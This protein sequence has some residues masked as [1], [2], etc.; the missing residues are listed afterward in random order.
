MN[1]ACNYRTIKYESFSAL[2]L[3][4]PNSQ[5]GTPTNIEHILRRYF[6]SEV[7]RDA[8]CDQ[9]KENS[10]KQKGFL[11]KHGIVKMPQTLLIRLERVGMLPSGHLKLN[12]HVSFSEHL[13]VQEVC[14]RRDFRLRKEAYEES[15]RKWE[16]ADGSARVFGGAEI[17]DGLRGKVTSSLLESSDPR[18]P[19]ISHA[20]LT[21]GHAEAERHTYQLRAV[22]EHRGGPFSG[23]F[24]T[25]RRGPAPNS[26]NWFLTNDSQV[27]QVAYKQ[28][29][30]CQAYMLF[31]ERLKPNRWM[32]EPLPSKVDVIVLGTGLP[33][34]I[35]AA[36][37]A[38]SGL[39]VVHLDR[40]PFY[41]ADWTSLNLDCVHEWVNTQAP[42][43]ENADV[44]T[45]EKFLEEGEELVLL[46]DNK[47]VEDVEHG[48]LP[49][50]ST[51]IRKEEE[52]VEG[53]EKEEKEE[54]T[55]EEILKKSARRFSIDVLPKVLLA[56]G[57]MVQVLCDSQVSKY[58]EF[59]L[60]DRQLCPLAEAD[61][62]ISFHRVPC[63]KGEIFTSQVLSTMDKRFLM[64]FITF[65]TQWRAS[66]PED[67]RNAI[68]DF[69]DKPF[70]EFLRSQKLPENLRSYI[71]STIGILE[72]QPTTAKGLEAVC[73][74]M[75]SVGHFGPSPFLFPLYGNG[76]MAQYY[77]RLSAVFGSLYCLG[78]PIDFVV[79]K[80][81][82]I[83][84]VITN[85]Q[86]VNCD[87]VIMSQ[88]YLPKSVPLNLTNFQIQRRIFITNRS[89]LQEDKEFITLIN[90][91][92]LRN[93]TTTRIIEAGFE[94]CLAP[95][96]YLLVHVTGKEDEKQDL[97]GFI[98]RLFKQKDISPLWQM[99]FKMRNSVTEG[100]DLPENVITT[101]SV[102]IDL[103]FSSLIEECRKLFCATWPDRDF[104]PRMIE[105][106][107]E[108]EEEREVEKEEDEAIES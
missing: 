53:E 58:A 11:K 1:S 91:S 5:M 32:D 99:R 94:A 92:S 60:V 72:D 8:T 12:E 40:N 52:A 85:G 86:R 9:C 39:S 66:S 37:C 56:K 97:D 45:F 95:K 18:F 51:S 89:I 108:E 30:L 104:L 22:C 47:L 74:F 93:G 33:E 14:F 48:W 62:N 64:K 78:K 87:H 16:L 27:N 90:A 46:G 82:R 96:G 24:V 20:K 70:D 4:I 34:A 59:K 106:N 63:S 84:G 7:I 19:S 3:T 35:L 77:C 10:R 25:Y 38:R 54:K 44:S 103:E 13:S 68:K 50:C 42:I 105:T 29:G 75:D 36:A 43:Q 88:T 49:A 57:D 67:A 101:P 73:R 21:E 83:V 81:N 17:V 31:Y 55:H 79:K 80:E 65:C 23:H 69:A 2:T 71:T 41:G 15:Q 76:E 102:D 107:E 28:V 6:C 26:F 98:D 61:G 100:L